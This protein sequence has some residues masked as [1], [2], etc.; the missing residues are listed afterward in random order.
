[1]N[2]CFYRFINYQRTEKW[3]QTTDIQL[4]GCDVQ[5]AQRSGEMKFRF[6]DRED[7]TF[8]EW[9]TQFKYLGRIPEETDSDWTAVHINTNNS[10]AVW[11]RLEKLPR[12][13]GAD[14]QMSVLFYRAVVQAVPIV[15]SESWALL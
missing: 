6:Y 13:E 9:V 10:Q 11:W 12:R 7:K 2:D 1:M 3:N 4:W 5:I 15:S 8:I 14:I